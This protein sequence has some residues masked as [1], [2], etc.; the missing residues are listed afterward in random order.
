LQN[1]EPNSRTDATARKPRVTLW[2][3]GDVSSTLLYVK[4]SWLASKFWLSL[5]LYEMVISISNHLWCRRG[6]TSIYS[7]LRWIQQ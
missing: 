6:L 2:A 5:Y 1:K 4:Y 7:F 3:E